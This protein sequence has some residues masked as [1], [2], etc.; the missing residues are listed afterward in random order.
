[1]QRGK[2]LKQQFTEGIL[3]LHAFPK[4]LLLT[5]ILPEVVKDKVDLKLTI[6]FFQN[7]CHSVDT[8][9]N[10][11]KN[12]FHSFIWRLDSTENDSLQNILGGSL[13]KSK[14]TT[15]SFGDCVYFGQL[16]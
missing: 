4:Y 1:M 6:P 15:T 10:E 11:D 12:P 8:L 14:E 2:L 5:A 13:N 7:L 3:F 16:V 9:S